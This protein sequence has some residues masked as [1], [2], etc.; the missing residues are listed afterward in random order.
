MERNQNKY[1]EHFAEAEHHLAY[2]LLSQL[3][4]KTPY[5]HALCIPAYDESIESCQRLFENINLLEKEP[6]HKTHKNLLLFIVNTPLSDDAENSIAQA[7]IGNM[8]LAA[9]RSQELANNIKE[10]YQVIGQI[11]HLSLHTLSDNCD[12]LLI[13]RIGELGLPYKQGVGLARKIANDCAARLMLEN[14]ISQKIMFNTDADVQLPKDY[15]LQI[16]QASPQLAAYLFTFQHQIIPNSL[17]NQA[18]Q[19]YQQS[20]QHYV[21][22]LSYA[23]SPFAFHTVGSTLAINLKHYLQVRGFSKKNAGEDFYLL[24]KLRKIAKIKT[25]NGQ[26]LILSARRSHRVPFGTGPAIKAVS[27]NHPE[28]A[29]LFFDQAC[30]D[31]L[32]SFISFWQ[33]A[34]THKQTLKDLQSILHLVNQLAQNSL[35]ILDDEIMLAV[36]K[37]KSESLQLLHKLHHSHTQEKWQQTFLESFDALQTLKCLHELRDTHFPSLSYA[38]INSNKFISRKTL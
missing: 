16:E 31:Y 20:L 28:N 27:E 38:E 7:Q 36:I 3:K 21:D 4:L 19:I 6:S 2:Q 26:A 9:Q 10:A 33:E 29:K 22:G 15:F 30:F 12:I 37:N 1:F 25:L 34:F 17:D 18:C 35:A 23:N 14:F 8:Q 24:N 11:E 5:R 32:R 13:Q